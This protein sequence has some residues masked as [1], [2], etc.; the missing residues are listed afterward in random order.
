MMDDL[1]YAI[2][3]IKPPVDLES[4]YEQV[5]LAWNEYGQQSADLY[6]AEFGKD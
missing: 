3:G 5:R 6:P 2:K 1:R 4:T